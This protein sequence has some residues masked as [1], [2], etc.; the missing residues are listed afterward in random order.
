[1]QK[2]ASTLTKTIDQKVITKKKA[3]R[4]AGL[5][6]LTIGHKLI[7]KRKKAYKRKRAYCVFTCLLVYLFTCLEKALR[8]SLESSEV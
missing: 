5:T 7:L 8:F 3:C 6:R 4:D 1:M 2:G